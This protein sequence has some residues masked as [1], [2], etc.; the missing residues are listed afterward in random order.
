MIN[1]HLLFLGTKVMC[2]SFLVIIVYTAKFL[3]I[4]IIVYFFIV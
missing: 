2:Y 3:I 4:E 1:S